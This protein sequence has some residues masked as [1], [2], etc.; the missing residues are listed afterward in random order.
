M[1]KNPWN[2][3]R[4]KGNFCENDTVNWTPEMKKALNYDPKSAQQFDN[5]NNICNVLC[6]NYNDS[7]AYNVFLCLSYSKLN[8]LSNT[9]NRL[10]NTNPTINLR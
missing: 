10:S 8:K 3:L 4:W 7:S 6:I 1:L 9:Q 2:H 5:G